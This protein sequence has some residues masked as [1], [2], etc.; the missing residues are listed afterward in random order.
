M[1]DRQLENLV[2]PGEWRPLISIPECPKIVFVDL[3]RVKAAVSSAVSHFNQGTSHL[4]Q[5]MA[6]LDIAPSIIME[7]YQQEK[8]KRR[9]EQSC[10]H[11]EPA[12]KRQRAEK[13]AKK[14]TARLQAENREGATY[15]AG[16]LGVL[17]DSTDDEQ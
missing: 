17:E 11:A 8:D 2:A 1:C 9:C 7:A 10:Q 16:L 3:D 5:V 6:R 12:F 4:S 14:K 15:D 13:G